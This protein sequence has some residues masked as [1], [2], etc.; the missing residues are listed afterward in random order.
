MIQNSSFGASNNNAWLGT[1]N[2]SNNAYY[3]NSN[4]N[5]N[6][7]NQNN[8]YVVAP[9]LLRTDMLRYIWHKKGFHASIPVYTG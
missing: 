4:G 9:A 2:G 7:N 8:S 3:V 6:N 1:Y 5:V